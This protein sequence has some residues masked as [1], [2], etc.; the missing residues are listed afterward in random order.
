[1]NRFRIGHQRIR[2]PMKL[3]LPR[4]SPGKRL[5]QLLSIS[6]SLATAGLLEWLKRTSV[7]RQRRLCLSR[8]WIR[9]GSSSATHQVRI[10]V[11]WNRQSFSIENRRSKI[12]N[13]LAVGEGFIQSC[14]LA[15]AELERNVQH[16][17]LNE[18]GEGGIRTLGSLLGYGALAKRC[19]QPLSH[20]TKNLG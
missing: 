9:G 3:F 19:F 7:S 10:S 15:L 2:Y 12:E 16:P 14:V 5:R 17:T 18:T 11:A 4:R 13:R 20:L 6:Q 8:N 1:M